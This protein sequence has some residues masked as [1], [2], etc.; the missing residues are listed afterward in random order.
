MEKI[1]VS[2]FKLKSKSGRKTHAVEEEGKLKSLFRLKSVANKVV[3]TI[4]QV[5]HFTL[6]K[7]IVACDGLAAVTASIFCDEINE[8]KSET[9]GKLFGM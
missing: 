9:V 7:L 8:R 5:Q 6:D 3:S 1:I 4:S 2:K